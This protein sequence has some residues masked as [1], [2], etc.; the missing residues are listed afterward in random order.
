MIPAALQRIPDE[1]KPY[2]AMGIGAIILVGLVLVHGTGIHVILKLHERGDVRLRFGRPHES[3]AIALFGAAVFLLLFA[4][5]VE[6]MV[7]AFA[8]IGLGLV[9]RA[10]D[11]IYFCANAYTTLGYGAVDL[12]PH[13][14]NISPVIGLSG[15]FAFAWTTGALVSIVGSHNRLLTELR[16]ERVREGALRQTLRADERHVRD[17]EAAAEAAERAAA[18]RH[19]GEPVAERLGER[20]TDRWIDWTAEKRKIDALR[21]AARA[22]IAGLEHTERL[23]EDALGPGAVLDDGNA[24]PRA[25]T[26][27]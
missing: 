10:H 16:E 12:E 4:H 8:L 23:A 1:F 13:W 15:M 3:A 18:S 26:K 19:T 22:E 14:R 11:A 2:A 6:I 25:Q 7:W 27:A 9:E 21:A 24:A 5:L 17:R 20:L